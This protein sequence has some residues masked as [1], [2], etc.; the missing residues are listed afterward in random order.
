MEE[1]YL[2]E[3]L[4]GDLESGF[5]A[6]IYPTVR[7]ESSELG[8]FIVIEGEKYLYLTLINNISLAA[9]NSTIIDALT[10]NVFLNDEDKEIIIKAT[11]GKLLYQQLSLKPLICVNRL[12]NCV[13][14]V[15]T[16]PKHLAKIRRATQEDINLI[17]GEKNERNLPIGFPL[18]MDFELNINIEKLLMRNTGIF[19][20]AGSGKSFLAKIL[21]G[22]IIASGL[23]VVLVFDMHNEYG[24]LSESEEGISV[25]GLKGIFPEDVVLATL[26]PETSPRYDIAIQ[27]S[28]E[29]IEPAD[30]LACAEEMNLSEP[31]IDAVFNFAKKFRKSWLK[32][33]LETETDTLEKT[34]KI[35]RSTIQALKRRLNARIHR[36]KFI[37]ETTAERKTFETLINMLK[38]GKSIILEFGR[39]ETDVSAY[40]LV[41]NAIARRIHREYVRATREGWR[42]E[43]KPLMIFIEEA[44]KFLGPKVARFSIFN[45]IAREMRKYM[46]T[47][48]IVDQRP[49]QI[50]DEVLSQI[51]TRFILALMDED[52]IKAAL[53]G[54]TE[55]RE[56]KTIVP[57]LRRQEALVFGYA[58][59]SPAVFRV[60]NY[61]DKLF[62][63]WKKIRK[64]L[65]SS[66]EDEPEQLFEDD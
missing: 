22:H 34:T 26:D 16:V 65:V 4:E 46:V 3:I 54:I 35:M 38:D 61:D 31:M 7:E 17:F 45:T 5:T 51:W 43:L 47:L 36:F 53:S 41:A 27:L 59:P 40:I 28:L 21:A 15:K 50:H 12:D 2:G 49:S 29:D 33:L 11:K 14:K 44:H 23:G 9:V 6:K 58:L 52:D 1:R 30:I 20:I 55:V 56:M 37:N 25:K 18:G 57:S 39:Y 10:S 24:W 32:E 63:F 19:A 62:D 42:E 48:C 60:I 64:P 66:Y 8:Q 13:E